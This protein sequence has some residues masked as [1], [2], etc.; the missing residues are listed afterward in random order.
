MND[1]SK[2][3][4]PETNL[5][6]SEQDLLENQSADKSLL[7]DD[8]SSR[9]LL[10]TR[11]SAQ[12]VLEHPSYQELLAKFSEEEKKSQDF[13]NKWLLTQA[14]LENVKRRTERDITNAHKYAL[15]KFAYEILTTVD[16]LERSLFTRAEENVALKD[17][18]VGI[19]L[20]LKHLLEVLQKFGITPI[21]PVGEEFNHEKHTAMTMREDPTVKSNVVL[22]V[23][24][25]GYWLKDRLL[26]PAL[27]IVA[28]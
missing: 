6:E 24:Q 4:K 9:G 11:I 17:F 21:N 27:V 25:K 23:I 14:D 2:Q 10:E 18:Y 22:E 1:L 3:H 20:T 12:M 26:R 8:S 19:E 13:Y 28:K 15:E 7:N 16:N 5:V